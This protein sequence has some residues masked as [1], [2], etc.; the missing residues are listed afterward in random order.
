[1]KRYLFSCTA[2]AALAFL[3]SLPVAAQDKDKDKDKDKEKS[4]LSDN[5]QIIIKRKGDKD[6]KVT[7]EIKGD[8]VTVNGKPLDEF[9]DDDIV[10]HKGGNNSFELYGDH[11]P[12][13]GQ[14]GAL[15]FG[16]G[17]QFYSMDAG[18]AA[19]LGVATEKADNGAKVVELTE[20]SAA[21]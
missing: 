15:S 3:L 11:S 14:S 1:M 7:I 4:K 13:R 10:I 2:F 17:N 6:V 8:E 20:G 12:F 5:E 18:N 16:E 9:D 21:D 19:L